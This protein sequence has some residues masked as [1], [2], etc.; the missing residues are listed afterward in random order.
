M[1]IFQG[2]RIPRLLF[3]KK[4]HKGKWKKNK[5]VKLPQKEQQA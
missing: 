4:K 2:R 3:K 1:T 5:R